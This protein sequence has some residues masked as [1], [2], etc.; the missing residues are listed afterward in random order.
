MVKPR[1]SGSNLSFS[2]ARVLGSISILAQ[3]KWGEWGKD[4]KKQEVLK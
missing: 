4:K 3:E 2:S 1:I